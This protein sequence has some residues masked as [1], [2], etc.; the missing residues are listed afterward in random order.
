MLGTFTKAFSPS[1]N[2][3]RVFFQVATSQMCNFPNVHFPSGNFPM[4]ENF[5]MYIFPSNNFLK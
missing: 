1:G 2:F 3:P 4:K 5:Q